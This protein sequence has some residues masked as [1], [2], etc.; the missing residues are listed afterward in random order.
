MLK[1]AI[2]NTHARDSRI[3]FNEAAHEYS[4]DGK[5]VVGSVSSL[6]ASRFE[7]FDARR[8]ASACYP[9]WAKK[10]REGWELDVWNC[11]K[12]YV[13]LIEGGEPTNNAGLTRSARLARASRRRG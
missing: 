4:I 12:K 13:Q 9:K 1:L 2:E 10:T 11:T 5:V 6:W 8:T 7:K 3:D